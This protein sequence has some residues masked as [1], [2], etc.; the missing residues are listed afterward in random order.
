MKVDQLKVNIEGYLSELLRTP[1][2]IVSIKEIGQ[3]GQTAQKGFGYGK[4]YRIDYIRDGKKESVVL[5]TMSENSFGHD[6]FSDRAQNL[7]WYFSASNH[8]PRHAKSIDVGAFTSRD[9]IISLGNA[10][11]F[12]IIS[13]FVEGNEYAADLNRILSSGKLFDQDVG[14]A[15]CLASYLV[16]IHRNKRVAPHLY[17]R[18]MRELLG[19]GECIMGLIDNYPAEDPIARP[20]VLQQIE[21][22]CLKWR[23]KIR[24]FTDR[25]C[26]IHGDFHPW[27]I[28][29]REQKDFTVVDRS[30]G[31]W[32]EAAD[33]VSSMIINYL[34]LSLQAFGRLEAHF[35]TLYQTFWRTYMDGTGDY[36]MKTVMQPFLAWR[37][38]VLANPIWYPRLE[39]SV[40]KSLFRFI[41]RVLENNTFEPEKVNDYL[42]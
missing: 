18:R 13:E 41:Q 23:W 28:L 24:N 15:R 33:D 3:K 6:H 31:E 11:E 1:V 32:G 25:L 21:E 30:R 39:N 12:F 40:R 8:L 37:G 17:K 27:N 26:E 2:S 38:L 29:F 35:E 14:R 9:S 16:N 22:M 5:E 4:P 10:Q 34:F 19:H 20:E 7:L 36:Q 42:V